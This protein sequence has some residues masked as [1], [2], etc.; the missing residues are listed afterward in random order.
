MRKIKTAGE[1]GGLLC[2]LKGLMQAWPL[3]GALK[4]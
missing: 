3:K 4:V 2:P 1:T